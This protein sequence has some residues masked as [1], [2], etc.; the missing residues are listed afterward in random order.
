MPAI[1]P[2]KFTGRQS[3]VPSA[4]HSAHYSWVIDGK[5]ALHR[6]VVSVA[7]LHHQCRLG[8]YAW[9]NSKSPENDWRY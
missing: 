3:S 6:A 9:I 8:A 4:M 1:S 2:K 5:I 7:Q